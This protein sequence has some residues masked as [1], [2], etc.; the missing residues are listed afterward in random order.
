MNASGKFSSFKTVKSGVGRSFFVWGLV[1]AGLIGGVSTSHSLLQAKPARPRELIAP[2]HDIQYFTFGHKEIL[3]DALWLRAIQDFDYCEKLV[4]QRD[5]R[6][7]SW[8]YQMLDVIT[9]LSPQFHMA[10][11][12]GSMALTVI[13]SDL[14]GASKFFDKAVR[15]FPSDWLINYKAA[16]HAIYEEKDP[17]KG[18]RL[19]EKSAQNG[20]PSWVHA[21]AGRLYT[22]AG[23]VEMAEML[24]R[25]LEEKGGDPK[26]IEAIRQRIREHQAPSP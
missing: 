14:T 24:A 12:A 6:S 4:N 9:D 23:Q 11:S 1:I 26:I 10:Y 20:A 15:N 7:G 5:C 22:Q 8:L 25:D 16:Y 13:I 2:P 3:A 17:G 19:I 18:A 21:L